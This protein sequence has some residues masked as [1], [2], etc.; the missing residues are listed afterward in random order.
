MCRSPQGG[1]AFEG[2]G[3]TRGTDHTFVPSG[4]MIFLTYRRLYRDI[5]MDFQI[6]SSIRGHMYLFKRRYKGNIIHCDR[7][8]LLCLLI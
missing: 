3:G 6:K 2:T 7:L 4:T 8:L 1:F 5:I